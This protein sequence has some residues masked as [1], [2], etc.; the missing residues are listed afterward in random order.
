VWI[1]CC[2]SG[3]GGR[4]VELITALE[5]KYGPAAPQH[6]DTPPPPLTRSTAAVAP[7]VLALHCLRSLAALRPLDPRKHSSQLE[8]GARGQW[9]QQLLLCCSGIRSGVGRREAGGGGERR[10]GQRHV[11]VAGETERSGVRRGV[12]RYRISIGELGVDD[13]I[14]A[15]KL[16][17][18]QVIHYTFHITRR[19][20]TTGRL[21]AIYSSTH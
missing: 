6:L 8:R 17:L 12:Y 11:L 1:R 9:Y 7:A 10:E 2:G 20:T 14:C 3:E 16:N 15:L 19:Q 18:K 4:E 5:S 13:I 21:A